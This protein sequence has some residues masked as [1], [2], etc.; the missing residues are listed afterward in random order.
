MKMK[1]L[2][3]LI[4]AATLIAQSGAV[5]AQVGAAAQP[6]TPGTPGTPTQES[7]KEDCSY[8]YVQSGK[9]ATLEQIAKARRATVHRVIG[10]EDIYVEEKFEVPGQAAAITDNEKLRKQLRANGVFPHQ[11]IG[12]L[13]HRG[14]LTVFAR[15]T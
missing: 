15:K 5:Y 4:I 7:S 10:C 3:S 11:V 8:A 1:T 12:V 6:G 9:R 2:A 14:R 13:T